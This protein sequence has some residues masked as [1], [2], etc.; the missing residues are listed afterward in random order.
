MNATINDREGRVPLG[1]NRGPPQ[2]VV[3]L[4]ELADLEFQLP[5]LGQLLGRSTAMLPPSIWDCT[6]SRRTV[7]APT[8][9]RSAPACATAGGFGYPRRVPASAGGDAPSPS[10][11]SSSARGH[12]PGLPGSGTEHLGRCTNPATAKW[13]AHDMRPQAT[14]VVVDLHRSP[15]GQWTPARIYH[16]NPCSVGPPRWS[17]PW[18]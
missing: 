11:R 18:L 10:D 12:R 14:P 4:V 8:P 1:E 3:V 16:C 6:S 13:A 9:L 5:D 15:A 17:V 2:D 7:S